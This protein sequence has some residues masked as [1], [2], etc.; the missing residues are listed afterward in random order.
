MEPRTTQRP[1]PRTSRSRLGLLVGLLAATLALFNARESLDF[2]FV[3]FD[4]DINI[5]F[6][7]H[8]G[9]PAAD[10][11][12]W[13]FTDADYMRRYL[14][15]GWL[16]LSAAYAAS[17]LSPAGYHALNLAL[18]GVNAGLVFA[19]IAAL[20]GRYGPR[21]SEGVRFAAAGIA[22]ALWALHPMR[23]ETVGWASGLLYAIAGGLALASVL[24][25][26]RATAL[27]VAEP[28]RWR[29]LLGS[30]LLYAMS[31]L[32]Y[33]MSLGVMAAFVAI[34][35]MERTVGSNTVSMRRL[36]LEKLPLLLPGLASGWI[37]WLAEKTAPEFWSRPATVEQFGFLPRLQ[38]AI[39]AAASYLWRPWWLGELTPAPTWLFE[40]SER[41][42]IA[43]VAGVVLF[44][45]T[46]WLA[47][48]RSRRG[49]LLLWV[50]H[51]ALLA[52]ML[53][54]AASPHF[55]N[56][57][58]DYLAAVVV[59]VAV[60][61]VL[62]RGW[63]RRPGGVVAASIAAV[64]VIAAWA[65]AQR[66]QLRIWRTTDTLLERIVRDARDS[67]FKAHSY[68]RW[69]MAHLGTGDV[70]GAEE[71]V[72]RAQRET[73]PLIAP[74]AAAALAEYAAT[75]RQQPPPV[76]LAAALHAKLAAEFSRMGR[77]REAENH[78]RAA[79][80]VKPD[81][82]AA[83]LNYAVFLAATGRPAEAWSLYARRVAAASDAA[84]PT[85][86][87]TRFLSLLAAAFAAQN[88]EQLALASIDLAV[89]SAARAREGANDVPS[90]EALRAQRAAYADRAKQAGSAR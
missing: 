12:R 1:V 60:A 45:L 7:P 77:T 78:F 86:V 88:R 37:A 23:A 43:A 72:R 4:D 74:R 89:Q 85:G 16:T 13:M 28:R 79:L 15:F 20:L 68:W 90:P 56:D 52:P 33:P 49:A 25:Y 59:A 80:E 53:G 41:R 65:H 8:L 67:G 36:A 71:V 84:V 9:P 48:A 22:A 27:P 5:V 44:G 42:V 3:A 66:S 87:R 29:W 35:V 26:L 57:R 10:T 14:P 11:V 19:L 54:W 50:V 61:V 32:A 76:P 24:A 51:F 2:G 58:Y 70:A 38:Q 21:R 34:D 69:T 82:A 31:V 39:D 62:L 46:L 73:D 40:L 47:A 55:P 63:P 17:D 18:H 81:F 83:A 64:A 75:G 30:A 6:N